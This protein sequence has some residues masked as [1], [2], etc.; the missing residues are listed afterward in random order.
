MKKNLLS[1]ALLIALLISG[2]SI[3]NATTLNIANASTT[4]N[5]MIITS[6]TTWTKTNSPYELTRNVLIDSGVTVAVEADAVVN[7]NSYYIRVNGTL[8]VQPGVTINMGS[9]K[10]TSGDEEGT[11]VGSIEVNGVMTARGTNANPIHINGENSSTGDALVDYLLDSSPSSVKFARSSIAWNETASS[12]CIIENAVLE[13]TGI[14]ASSSVKISNIKVSGAGISIADGSPVVSNNEVS[15]GISIV[16]GSPIIANN[17]LT[18]GNIHI[19]EEGIM[20]SPIITGNVISN[21][22]ISIG[23]S[24]KNSNGIILVENN[25]IQNSGQGIR[26]SDSDYGDSR[27]PVTIRCNTILDNEIGIAIS[28]MISPSTMTTITNNNI[29][30]NDVGILIEAIPPSTIIYNNIYNNNNASIKLSW[31]ASHDVNATLNWWGT[32][33]AST[34]DKSIYDFNDDFNL[35]KVNYTPL[36]TAPNPQATPNPN[37]SIPSPETSPSQSPSPDTSPSPPENQTPDQNG[38]PTPPQTNFYG[39]ALAILVVILGIA[40]LVVGVVLTR[41][42]SHQTNIYAPKNHDD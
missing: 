6:D 11:G 23:G 4:V 9:R 33:D 22:G 21:S 7:L 24:F 12:G 19:Y 40:L 37:A 1:N 26:V 32:T 35:G 17:K 3:V 39:I 29:N 42:K 18:G 13:T 31:A 36:L 8:I 5:S 34:I 14:T 10:F 28:D 20:G 15:G 16:G 38:N 27:K 41:K 2:L 25:V 30:N